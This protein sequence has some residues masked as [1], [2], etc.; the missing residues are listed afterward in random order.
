[1]NPFLA[2]H[3]YDPGPTQRPTLAGTMAGI[4]ATA[5]A[6][7]LLWQ[8]G[9]LDVEARILG[10]TQATTIL[11]GELAMAAAGALYGWLFKRAANDPCGGWLF[12][13]AYGFALWAAGAVMVLPAMSGGSAPGGVPAIGILLALLAWGTAMGALFPHL[14]RRLHPRIGEDGRTRPGIGPMAAAGRDRRS[15]SQRSRPAPAGDDRP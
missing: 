10:L 12:G 5:A 13:M 8:F 2:A 15:P 9:S 7:P 6:I 4:A 11:A 14:H 3:G 1:M